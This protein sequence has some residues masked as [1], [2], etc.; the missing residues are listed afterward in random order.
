VDPST[1]L[2]L[3][4]VIDFIYAADIPGE[5]TTNQGK[6]LHFD[7]SHAFQEFL[8]LLRRKLNFMGNLSV[9]LLL[10]PKDM[11]TVLPML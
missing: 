10:T 7:F 2:S 11:L 9:P 3:P 4:G 1:A 5:N 8:S 6:T